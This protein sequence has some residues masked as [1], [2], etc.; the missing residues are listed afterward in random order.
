M[1]FT[2]MCFGK[3]HEFNLAIEEGKK[4]QIWLQSNMVEETLCKLYIFEFKPT[5]NPNLK[6]I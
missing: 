2:K 6:T 3:E 5:E 4:C 1:I